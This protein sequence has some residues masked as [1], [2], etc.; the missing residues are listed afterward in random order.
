MKYA[1]TST[2]A[3]M[4]KTALNKYLRLH[5]LKD[6]GKA[7]KRKPLKFSYSADEIRNLNRE[8]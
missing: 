2:V 4:L 1:K 7:I 5:K 8:I 6:L 3:D